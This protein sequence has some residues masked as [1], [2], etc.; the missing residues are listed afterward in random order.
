MKQC[1]KCKSEKDESEFHKNKSKKD[2]LDHR[3][4]QC[5]A[6]YYAAYY[7]EHREEIAASGAA[8]RIEHKEEIVASSAAY[9][10]EH[11]EEIAASGAAYYAEHKGERAVYSA[12][13]RKTPEGKLAKKKHANERK[14]ALG[15][16][17]LNNE[18]PGSHAHHLLYNGRY[19]KDPDTVIYIPKE[20]HTPAH[21]R[22]NPENQQGVN[23]K[24]TKWLMDNAETE[25]IRKVAAYSHYKYC[26]MPIPM[27]FKEEYYSVESTKISMISG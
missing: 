21:G 12:A 6:A 7:A 11:R 20:L 22:K 17:P 10:A 13:Y 24:A 4:K 27:W 14:R 26:L 8:Y 16:K 1:S 23:I 18:F 2:G 19:E 5:Q 9:Y 3:C 25:E 15:F